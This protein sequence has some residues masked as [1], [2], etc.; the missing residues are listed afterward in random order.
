MRIFPFLI[1]NQK[2]PPNTN[3]MQKFGASEAQNL[4]DQKNICPAFDYNTISN[5]KNIPPDL[6]SSIFLFF[7]PLFYLA[8]A[9]KTPDC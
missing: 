9:K 7:S 2:L 6:S 1:S 5:C 4:S 8:K 3:K